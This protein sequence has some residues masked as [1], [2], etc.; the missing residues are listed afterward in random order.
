MEDGTQFKASRTVPRKYFQMQIKGSHCL[1]LTLLNTLGACR[2]TCAG[3]DMLRW[4]DG[5]PAAATT[6]SASRPSWCCTS[7][8]FP[9]CR[10]TVLSSSAACAI[11]AT[12]F[13][14][15]SVASW[16][17]FTYIG[18]GI[19][20]RQ[21]AR[22]FNQHT[23]HSSKYGQIVEFWRYRP[24]IHYSY[25][26]STVDSY[27]RWQ[28]R[29]LLLSLLVVQLFHTVD[30]LWIPSSIPQCSSTLSFSP[31]NLHFKNNFQPLKHL[32]SFFHRQ[33]NPYKTN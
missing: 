20:E 28:L 24:R 8:E 23:T 14:M 7:S 1:L 6:V 31:Q 33:Q 4:A 18:S 27:L 29:A 17:M 21:G 15:A 2:P 19:T 11:L 32:S 25:V 16:F 13:C 30:E 3:M 22:Y 5:V 12:W 10:G 9:A 26:S